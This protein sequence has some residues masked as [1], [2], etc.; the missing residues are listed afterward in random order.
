MHPLKNIVVFSLVF[1][2]LCTG[3][4]IF[5][6]GD[7][8]RDGRTDLQDVILSVKDL[9]RTAEKPGALAED[10]ARVVTTLTAVAGLRSVIKPA[11]DSSSPNYAQILDTPCLTTS[12][13]QMVSTDW[14]SRLNVL[15]DTFNS[16]SSKPILPPPQIS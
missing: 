13:A 2:M 8:S 1:L 14:W 15:T 7:L 11:Q 10:L 6:S 16:I 4:P 3:L 12:I 5:H 9:A